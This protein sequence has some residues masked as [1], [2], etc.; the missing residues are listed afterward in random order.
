MTTF[1]T[2]VDRVRNMFAYGWDQRRAF[3]LLV[4]EGVDS[5][6][7]F[8]AVKGAAVLGRLQEVPR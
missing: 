3:Q 6:T 4:S 8:F 5:N 7:A 1:E 2:L